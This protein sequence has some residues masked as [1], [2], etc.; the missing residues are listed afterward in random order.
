[1]MKKCEWCN[2]VEV[3]TTRFCSVLCKN[4]YISS[5]NDY[6]K[7][8]EQNQ[9][10]KITVPCERCGTEFQKRKHKG[11][12]QRFCG[13][14]CSASATNKTKDY[15]AHSANLKAQYASGMLVSKNKGTALFFN[16]ECA[17][18]KKSFIVNAP[19][20]KQVYCSRACT[21]QGIK[22]ATLRDTL[23]QYRRQCNFKFGLGTFPLEFEFDLIRKHGWY[24]PTNKKNN[25]AG[26]SRDHRFSVC[27]GFRL[28]VDPRM[29]RHP[30]NCV[31]MLHSEN[32]SKLSGCSITLDE[33]KLK[34]E[35]WD[36]KY[37]PK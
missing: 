33:L 11:I 7:I 35:E 31:L 17:S 18:C 13:H 26:I 20:K 24:S 37:P 14:S 10:P 29:I 21:P 19:R 9:K 27:E 23:V 12:W 4:R 3:T 6:K 15:K 8:G 30:A 28:G 22:S 5:R 1:M 34:I 32:I 25:L 2:E 36:R 16:K